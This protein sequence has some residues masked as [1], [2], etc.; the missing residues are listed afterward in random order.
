MKFSWASVV[1]ISFGLFICFMGYFV[2]K[3]N[4]DPQLKHQLVTPNYYQEELKENQRN[5]AR[6]NAIRWAKHLKHKKGET[7]LM[8]Y[9]LPQ[10]QWFKVEGYRPSDPKK[11]FLITAKSEKEGDN[12]YLDNQNFEKGVWK[13]SL[14]WEE[15]GREFRIDY[16]LNFE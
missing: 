7:Y 12:I 1:L 9:P 6:K 4:T 15:M 8:L 14:Q 3:I 11:D 2:V 13:L 16:K 5:L 10:D